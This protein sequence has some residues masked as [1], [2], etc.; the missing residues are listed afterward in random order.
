MDTYG[1]LYVIWRCTLAGLASLEV[2]V[3]TEY[4]A[5]DAW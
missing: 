5:H 3:P 1:V 2:P 4:F